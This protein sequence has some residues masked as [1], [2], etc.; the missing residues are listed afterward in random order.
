MINKWDIISWIDPKTKSPHQTLFIDGT[1]SDARI[2]LRKLKGYAQ[3]PV[4]ANKPYTYAFELPTDIDDIT[5]EKIYQAVREGVQ[6]ANKVDQFVPGG[7]VGDPL[8]NAQTML[9][10]KAYPTFLALDSSENLF[11]KADLPQQKNLDLSAATRFFTQLDDTNQPLQAK[12]VKMSENLEE[13]VAQDIAPEKP[14]FSTTVREVFG[15]T[16]PKPSAKED[17]DEFTDLTFEPTDDPIQKPEPAPELPAQPQQP[18]VG[19]QMPSGTLSI[20]DRDMLI[21]DM[22]GSMLEKMPLEDI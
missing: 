12:R 19:K 5:R 22:E 18:A 10:D 8:F 6:S 4:S 7:A 16:Q 11:G 2:M 14:T 20:N 9:E 1:E 13:T 15:T 17:K 21:K 3:P